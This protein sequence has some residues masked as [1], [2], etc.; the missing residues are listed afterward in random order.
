MSIVHIAANAG[1][2]RF[3]SIYQVSLRKVKLLDHPLVS[4]PVNRIRVENGSMHAPVKGR[5]NQVAGHR[6]KIAAVTSTYSAV[7]K[8][9]KRVRRKAGARSANLDSDARIRYA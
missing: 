2:L 7:L 9:V 4:S 3:V 5:S 6:L 1:T 8:R